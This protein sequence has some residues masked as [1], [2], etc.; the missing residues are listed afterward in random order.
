MYCKVQKTD[1]KLDGE[2]YCENESYEFDEKSKA[3][4]NLVK[5]GFLVETTKAEAKAEGKEKAKAEAEKKAEAGSE[6]K[7]EKTETKK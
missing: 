2:M 1:V 7:S 3:V 6:A 4:K 5:A